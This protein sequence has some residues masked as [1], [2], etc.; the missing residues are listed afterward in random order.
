M[1][2]LLLF[3]GVMTRQSLSMPQYFAVD[4]P[5][6]QASLALS[7]ISP[8]KIS[9]VFQ[10]FPW[11][12]PNQTVQSSSLPLAATPLENQD[13]LYPPRA[14]GLPNLFCSCYC[15]CIVP[16]ASTSPE[17]RHTISLARHPH[18]LLREYDQYS[19]KRSGRAGYKIFRTMCHV[20]S[21]AELP[22]RFLTAELSPSMQQQINTSS[23]G[24][25]QLQRLIS[26]SNASSSNVAV[27]S[28]RMCWQNVWVAV[29]SSKQKN[30][31]SSKPSI[32]TWTT[33]LC[34]LKPFSSLEPSNW[35]PCCAI[36]TWS[37]VEC[38]MWGLLLSLELWCAMRSC[39]RKLLLEH[40]LFSEFPSAALWFCAS[41][42]GAPFCNICS[43][44]AS[45]ALR[46]T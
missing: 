33:L 9:S 2:P 3:L 20:F 4:P 32:N 41:D 28:N 15:C 22:V 24:L 16:H 43:F 44:Q 40:A 1:V 18:H 31:C 35:S 13:A 27:S 17:M 36:C 38:D 37:G 7:A 8:L 25:R 42:L 39:M 14:L 6:Q 45:A 29:C 30:I 11:L 19:C 5:A 26:K 21:P 12:D 46:G 34:D 10:R 23:C